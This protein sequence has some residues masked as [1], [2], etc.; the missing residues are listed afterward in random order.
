M[1]YNIEYITLGQFNIISLSCIIE[2]Y[3][4]IPKNGCVHISYNIYT[5]TILHVS[6]TK[7]RLLI[8][9]YKLSYNT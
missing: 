4:N 8:L 3:Q 9:F 6:E 2:L 5:K 1:A 7:R